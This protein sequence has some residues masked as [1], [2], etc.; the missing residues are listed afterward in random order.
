MSIARSQLLDLTKTVLNE[1]G[2]YNAGGI[3]LTYV[4]KMKG[5]WRVSFN[6]TTT[7]SWSK[8]V[9]CFSVDA[10]SGEITFSALDNVWKI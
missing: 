6:Y 10:E 8:S 1:L 9:G 4:Q 7:M 5:E 2:I 3:E